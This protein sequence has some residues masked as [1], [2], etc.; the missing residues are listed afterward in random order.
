MTKLVDLSQKFSELWTDTTDSAIKGINTV[1]TYSSDR[2]SDITEQAKTSLEGSLNQADN[3]SGYLINSMQ[4]RLNSLLNSWLANHP[5]MF[6]LSQHPIITLVTAFVLGV[7]LWRLLTAIAFVITNTIDKV[8]L[9]VFRSP[10]LLFKS[11]FGVNE[12][13]VAEEEHLELTINPAQFKQIINQL[14]Q[15]TAQQKLIIQEIK[16]LKKTNNI[17]KPN[18]LIID[19]KQKPEVTVKPPRGL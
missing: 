10:I 7:I 9:W 5:I 13:V 16:T 8:W 17:D 15:I 11:L 12:K 14:N 2:L 18:L 6:W 3:L 1:T 4:T 19:K